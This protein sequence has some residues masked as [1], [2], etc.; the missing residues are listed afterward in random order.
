MSPPRY[1]SPLTLSA[2]TPKRK[3]THC[4]DV[5]PLIRFSLV[6]SGDVLEALY[7]RKWRQTFQAEKWE[8]TG[9]RVFCSRWPL[10][11]FFKLQWA[12]VTRP[13]QFDLL[14]TSNSLTLTK[15]HNISARLLDALHLIAFATFSLHFF[16]GF[17]WNPSHTLSLQCTGPGIHSRDGDSAVDFSWI[18]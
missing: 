1:V 10:T 5:V 17:T 15:M 6:H 12:R 16:L 7:A 4:D 3:S 2:S 13:L 14:P 18:S 8:R 9:L 11:A